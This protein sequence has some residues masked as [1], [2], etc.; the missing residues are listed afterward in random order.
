MLLRDDFR[1]DSRLQK[2]VGLTRDSILQKRAKKV[3]EV[4]AKGGEERDYLARMLYSMY[5]GDFISIYLAILNG[6][7]PSPVSTIESFKRDL[8]QF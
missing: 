4:V 7:D 5:L 8:A 3:I 1:L 2:R 6:L